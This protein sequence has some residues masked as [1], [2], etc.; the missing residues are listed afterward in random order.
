MIIKAQYWSLL[1]STFSRFKSLNTWYWAVFAVSIVKNQLEILIPEL[2]V[3]INAAKIIARTRMMGFSHQGRGSRK[4]W[5]NSPSGSP[6]IASG[7]QTNCTKVTASAYNTKKLK[8]WCKY[9]HQ[10]TKSA[11]HTIQISDNITSFSCRNKE[12]LKV[13]KALYRRVVKCAKFDSY[14]T[15]KM[16]SSYHKTSSQI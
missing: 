8:D 10:H 11:Q 15:I 7:S 6:I 9:R 12:K 5:I 13:S 2:I 4:P 1:L 14:Q 16:S 3:T